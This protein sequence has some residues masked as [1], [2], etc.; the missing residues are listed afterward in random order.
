MSNPCP[1][2]S[3]VPMAVM[4]IREVAVVM[5]LDRMLVEV[6]MDL[7]GAGTLLVEMAVVGV[8]GVGVA[9]ANRRVLVTMDVVLRG[10]KPYPRHHQA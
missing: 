9:M 4:N 10:G 3:G 1:G 6:G 8:M 7:C 2:H 5:G